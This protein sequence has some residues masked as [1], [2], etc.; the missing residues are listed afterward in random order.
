MVDELAL[1]V[2]FFEVDAGHALPGPFVR[3]ADA[4][5]PVVLIIG[6]A[7]TS[8]DALFL[9]LRRSTRECGYS[10]A[11]VDLPGQCITPKDRL[12]W[13][14]GPEWPIAALV[15]TL[16]EKIGAQPGRV[17]STLVCG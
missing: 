9:S 10:I 7:D 5:A 4:S 12:H 1:P 2:S 16:I 8:M 3:N 14:L 15:D 6:G 17:R 13:G 11:I